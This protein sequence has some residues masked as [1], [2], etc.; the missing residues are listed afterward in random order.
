MNKI[1]ISGFLI[2]V[3]LVFAVY[4]IQNLNVE[5]LATRN[6]IDSNNTLSNNSNSNNTT[7]NVILPYQTDDINQLSNLT[8]S[9]GE[10]SKIR[11]LP[12]PCYVENGEIICPCI[13]NK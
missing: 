8:I 6:G 1:K 5:S 3:T 10:S 13:D 9:A 12:C 2:A 4:T 7:L 11:Q